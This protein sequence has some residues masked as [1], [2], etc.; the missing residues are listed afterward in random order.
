MGHLAT[1][2][3]EVETTRKLEILSE[4]RR[5]LLLDDAHHITH[6]RIFE[7][8]LQFFFDKTLLDLCHGKRFL[9]CC[10]ISLDESG[11]TEL[12]AS[13]ITND[14]DHQIGKLER[15]DLTEYRFA[16]CSTRCDRA[17][18]YRALPAQN[19]MARRS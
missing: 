7:S 10:A 12:D 11:R 6:Q 1:T 15:I 19:C 3:A 4:D 9:R 14:D 2:K 18:R 8:N 5:P 17:S 13:E 16:R